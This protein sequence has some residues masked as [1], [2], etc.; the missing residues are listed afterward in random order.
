MEHSMSEPGMNDM[1]A[2]GAASPEVPHTPPSPGAQLSAY[3]TERGWTVEQVAKHLNLAPRQ[4]V[5]IESDDYA[6]L[7]GMPIVRGFVRAYAKLLKVDAAPLLAMLGGETVLA[8]QPLVPRKTLST[9]FSEAR[10]PSMAERPGLSSKWLIGLLVLVLLGVAIWAAQQN[11]EVTKLQ[12]SAATQV[13]DGLAY[14]SGPESKPQDK[15]PAKTEEAKPDMAPPAPVVAASGNQAASPA[16]AESGAAAPVVEQPAAQPAAP[17]T[18]APPVKNGLV[19]A[20][21]ENSWIEVRSAEGKR[22]LVS[23]LLKSGETETL[24]INEPVLLVIG[25]ASGVDASLRGEPLEIKA[26]KSNV[27][28]LNLK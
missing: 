27:A 12:Q 5:A 10:L 4:V 13:K 16:S 19:L 8:Q 2:G 7:P 28:R 20:A 25:N 11:S 21:R 1:P 6:S 26:G 3:R 24:E 15:A 22:S 9:P 18:S 23:R 14:L 17:E